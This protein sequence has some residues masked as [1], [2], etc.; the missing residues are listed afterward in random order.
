MSYGIGKQKAADQSGKIKGKG[1]GTSD[2]IK[3]TVPSGS[4]IM[5]KDSTDAIGE[6][7]LARLGQPTDVNLSNGEYQLPPDQVHAVGVQALEQ[8]TGQTHTPVDQPQLGIKRGTDKPELFFA[9]GGQVPDDTFLG[10]KKSAFTGTAGTVPVNTNK[11]KTSSSLN[12]KELSS[13]VTPDSVRKSQ[14]K[15][16]ADAGV[17]YGI[18]NTLGGAAKGI[19]GLVSSAGGVVV[20]GA[21]GLG[22]FV[23]GGTSDK[24]GWSYTDS[25]W[26]F[27]KEGGNQFQSGLRQAF[28]LT[29]KN[30]KQ[31]TT[32]A[33][34]PKATPDPT[35]SLVDKKPITTAAPPVANTDVKPTVSTTTQVQPEANMFD[36]N[37]VS[38][39]QAQIQP[40]PY[41]VQQ[42]GNSFSYTNPN[43]AAQARANGIPELQGA[44]GQRNTGV[45]GVK[46]FMANTSEM[47]LGLQGYGGNIARPAQAPQRTEAQEA[48]RR[49]IMRAASTPYAGARNG[50]LTAA[51]IRVQADMNQGD[52]NREN[53]IYK[54]DANNAANIEQTGMR[55]AGQT[56]RTALE[57]QS[58]NWRTSAGLDVDTQK[59]N[60]TND[61][62]NRQFNEEQLNNMPTRMKQAYELN[63]MKQYEAA[64]TPEEKQSLSEK[65]G[66]VRGQQQQQGSRVMAINGGETVDDKGNVI[67]NGDVLINNQTGQRI[68][69]TQSQ[70]LPL[71]MVK[72]VGTGNGKPVYEDANGN[73]FISG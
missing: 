33:P 42:K 11:Q 51:Q 30:A 72:Q 37:Q 65:L 35:Q 8:M 69:S 12:E 23:S 14:A 60:A 64:K 56:G 20:D 47:G 22:R 67:K 17:V 61:L 46:D 49:E 57:Q 6:E 34:P 24:D 31:T 29:P 44:G 19:G 4:Y 25:N 39:N 3:K 27:A 66:M 38:T 16:D 45:Q 43:A 68:D 41:A 21:R 70:G 48:E 28:G 5:P 50:Q 73:K 55:E 71:N 53:D 26:D 15:L 18:G 32:Q 1:T 36:L 54:T 7:N 59:F 63:I 10:I 58:A 62:A 52:A 40:N 9:N 13:L 2:E